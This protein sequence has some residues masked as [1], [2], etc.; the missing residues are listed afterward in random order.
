MSFI[1]VAPLRQNFNSR[2]YIRSD[3]LRR[4]GSSREQFQFTL[5]YKERRACDRPSG[6]N[7]LFQF[8]LL[9]KERLNAKADY[10]SFVISIHAPI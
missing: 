2:S 8:T 9:Y 10:S 3:W 5:L 7:K 4:F 1:T 6:T